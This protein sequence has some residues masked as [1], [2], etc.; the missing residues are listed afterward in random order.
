MRLLV[1]RD[2]PST[3]PIEDALG[4]G[5]RLL[6]EVSTGGLEADQSAPNSASP[7]DG[8]LLVTSLVH[9]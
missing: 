6:L 8:N 9:L 5:I 1:V 3:I 2:L 4:S 7:F